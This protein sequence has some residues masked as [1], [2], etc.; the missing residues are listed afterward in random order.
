MNTRNS[1]GSGDGQGDPS[2]SASVL[3][4]DGCSGQNGGIWF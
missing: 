4:V 1:V 2:G 3:Q